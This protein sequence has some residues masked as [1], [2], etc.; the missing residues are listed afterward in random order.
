M[1][2]YLLNNLFTRV[3]IVVRFIFSVLLLYF[4]VYGIMLK[5]A[6]REYKINKPKAE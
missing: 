4:Y 2:Y 1:K 5:M 3:G 6:R